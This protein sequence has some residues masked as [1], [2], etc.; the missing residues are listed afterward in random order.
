MMQK[1]LFENE[2]LIEPLK[3]AFC[4]GAVSRSTLLFGDCLVEMRK[5]INRIRTWSCRDW[6]AN[7]ITFILVA[8]CIGAVILF[9]AFAYQI[10]IYKLNNK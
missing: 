8:I 4:I 9:I 7:I 2:N 3:P 1:T 10:E 6:G 5:I